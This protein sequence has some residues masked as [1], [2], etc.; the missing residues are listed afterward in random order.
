[1]LAGDV[2]VSGC[3]LVT[4][5]GLGVEENFLSLQQNRSHMKRIPEWAELKGLEG[6]LASVVEN[7]EEKWIPRAKRRTMSKMSMMAVKALEEALSAA[8]LSKEDLKGKRT[9]LV[10]GSTT[11]SLGTFSDSWKEVDRDQSVEGQLSSSMFK[12]M[13]HSLAL[14]LSSYL[15]FEGELLSLS[16]AC[17]TS[18][19]AVW[20]GCQYLRAGLCDLVIAGGADEVHVSTCVA[21]D[22]A[23]ATATKFQEDPNSAS[24]PFDRE[25][26]GIVIAEG[27][28]LVILER[29]KDFAERGGKDVRGWIY[30]GAQSA[31][32]PNLANSSAASIAGTLR[33]ALKDSGVSKER[34]DYLNAHATGTILGDQLEAEGIFE[35]FGADGPWISSLKGHYGH[36]LAPCGALEVIM[37]LEMLRQGNL[38]GTKN[39][40]ELDPQLPKGRYLAEN[41]A[42]QAQLALS[43]SFAM[44][45]ANVSLVLGRERRHG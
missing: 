16:S 28:A 40:K 45:G 29:A 41:K 22:R 30:G 10:V 26:T 9:L 42:V 24:R 13:S 43:N 17:S 37:T 35:V 18:A 1:V 3:G 39:L 36:L 11:C 19:Q 31:Y 33:Q 23:K 14:N 8:G 2:L 21:F 6:P 4:P 38:I 32:G 5:L 12:V 25:R 44:G 20:V 15:D 27:A 7:F 34:I